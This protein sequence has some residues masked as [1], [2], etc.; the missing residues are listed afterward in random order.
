MKK[1]T[2]FAF[3]VAFTATGFAQQVD[4]LK[5]EKERNRI[6]KNA[7]VVL[8]GWS[9]A[10]IIV[11]GIATKTHNYEM[12]NFHQ[13]NVMW[14]SINLAI[15]G[16]GYWGAAKEKINN[17]VLSDVLKHQSRVEK[18]FLIN[19]GLDVVYMGA[20]LLLNKTSDNQ[21]N[22]GKFKGYG[23]SFMLQGGFLLVFDVINY[24]IHKKH[25]KQLKNSSDKLSL[26][27]GPGSVSLVYNF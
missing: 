15:A 1:L 16:L 26:T 6:Q 10:N 3:L 7:M 9:A 18:T 27:G 4:L 14:G 17:P 21:K 12:R 2:L 13:M 5:Y 23:N 20:G 8:A 25:G 22:P 24:A 19:A 11:S